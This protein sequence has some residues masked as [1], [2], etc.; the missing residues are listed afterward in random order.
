[1]S[2]PTS[3]HSPRHPG[4]GEQS[5]APQLR[6]GIDLAI[7]TVLGAMATLL[8]VATNDMGFVRDEAFYFAHAEGYQDWFVR[9]EAG[10]KARADALER[11]AILD[12]WRANSEHPP[13]DKILFGWS[14]RALGRKL[15]PA[16]NA[17]VQEGELL[18]DVTD[19]GPSHGFAA[20]ARVWLLRPQVVDGPSDAGPRRVV[21]GKVVER[22]DHR[23]TVRLDKSA[24][25]ATIQGICLPPGPA[26][27]H[28]K[29]AKGADSAKPVIRRTGCEVLESR[30]TYVLSESNAMR[31][32]GAV[33]GGLLVALL[34]LAA[35][36]M[37]AGAATAWGPGQTTRAFAVAAGVGWLCL[38]QPFY[39]AHLTCFDTTITTLLV[40]TTLAYH[41]SLR[42]RLWLLPTAVLWGLA[43]LS[44]HNALFLPIVLIAHWVWDGLVEGR[45]SAQF[46]PGS[47]R[48]RG[49]WLGLGLV[50]AVLLWRVHPLL[51]LAALVL[52]LNRLMEVST[53]PVPA[54]FFVMLPVGFLILVAGW[55]LLW[56]DT[57]D[58]F[59]RWIEF[60]V[61]H[62]HYMQ[63]WFGQVL[64]YPP[65]PAVF[66]WGMTLFTWPT[67]ML[68][69]FAL[70]L[71]AVYWPR[72]FPPWMHE[73]A[74]RWRTRNLVADPEHQDSTVPVNVATQRRE[75]T[76]RE[77]A[78]AE[79][80][81]AYRARLRRAGPLGL[82]DFGRTAELRS[83]DR[84]IL[85]S[86]I[87][88]M[89][90]ISMPGT[91]IFGG[92]KHWML[93]F[94][95]MLLIAARG[96][97]TVWRRLTDEMAPADGYAADME[98]VNPGSVEAALMRQYVQPTLSWWRRSFVPGALA[99]FMALLVLLPS[100]QA[101]ADA[102][103]QGTAYYN[104]LIGGIP[105]AADK[106][107]Q[108]QFWGGTTRALLEDVNRRAPAGALIW[109][110][111]S[112]WGAYVMYQREGWFRRDLH[113][114]TEATVPSAMGFYHHQKD[115]DDYELD[116]W[117]T[118]N[119][120]TPVAQWS[121]EGVPMLTVYEAP[122]K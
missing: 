17:H 66:A 117:K 79:R 23:A 20:G 114:T 78:H 116:L 86:A 70:G 43:L 33:F 97:Q 96:L 63:T 120:H 40:A 92:T 64:A 32:P 61:H 93:S 103:P 28:E 110:H 18:L 51:A 81:A 22:K 106:G 10:G 71:V 101:T 25:L 48:V 91:P 89:A 88:P 29:P 24:D 21:G 109:F 75:E 1:M 7:A 5:P 58:N 94:A 118:Y 3:P 111:K 12:T 85:L 6:R 26:V 73:L 108:R 57:L 31:F 34:Y 83:L 74:A 46:A 95:F 38:P 4:V 35:R 44:K 72:A 62:E 2:S 68:M 100:A 104:D 14:W 105:G 15:R 45:F 41:R 76:A 122:P 113:Y 56:V 11:K 13:L 80:V 112:A 69:A 121:L 90:L 84:L 37:F 55:P 39:H 27:A 8:I 82:D 67:V 119:R 87:W 9:V 19:L 115:H 60:H 16:A 50:A 30:A 65:F 52:P 98:G 54:A 53:P 59:M 77:L 102:H 42:S 36:L 47:S 49:M 99:W 107:M